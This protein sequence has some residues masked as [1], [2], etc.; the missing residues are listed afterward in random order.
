M[1]PEIEIK[2]VCL[3]LQIDEYVDS[4]RKFSRNIVAVTPESHSTNVNGFNLLLKKYI[5]KTRA[6]E[7]F[8]KHL[9]NTQ[10]G[11][12]FSFD[13]AGLLK[14]IRN[15]LCNLRRFIFPALKFDEF[16]GGKK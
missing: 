4:L 2:D 15:N 13:Y 11:F 10:T 6:H 14:K 8:V 3:L 9:F 16:D 12:T 5:S 7:N 1:V